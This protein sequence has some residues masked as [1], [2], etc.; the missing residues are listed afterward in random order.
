[1][2]MEK[3]V[4]TERS[5]WRDYRIIMWHLLMGFSSPLSSN[6]HLLIEYHENKVRGLI[7]YRPHKCGKINQDVVRML[8][9]MSRVAKVPAFV[10]YTFK[11]FRKFHVIEVSSIDVDWY[12]EGKVRLKKDEENILSERNFIKLLYNI[13]ADYSNKK[14]EE[15][16]DKILKD[17]DVKYKEKRKKEDLV[18]PITTRHELY[19]HNCPAVDVD[20]I[21]VRFDGD[22]PIPMALID[23][24]CSLRSM[25]SS[26]RL[27]FCSLADP[28]RIP[29]FIVRYNHKNF[30][31]WRFELLNFPTSM[32][33]QCMLNHK[34]DEF[35]DKKIKKLIGSI[36]YMTMNTYFICLISLINN[37]GLPVTQLAGD[38]P[39][40]FK[41][42]QRSAG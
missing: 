19:G 38:P 16:L 25:G 40:P 37:S 3:S 1:L 26:N 28:L 31:L 11:D 23:L 42:A 32:V 12:K 8:E 15:L 27:A 5:F 21:L 2:F 9:Y 7:V 17:I 33:G 4:N 36:N 18:P 22:T 24:K 6:D 30:D 20:F 39:V 35:V 10:A 14:L 41:P 34:S 29:A 13:R